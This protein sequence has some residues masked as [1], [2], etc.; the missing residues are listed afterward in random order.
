VDLLVTAVNRGTEE[1]RQALAGYPET[2]DR[3]LCFRD[4]DAICPNADLLLMSLDKLEG[5]IGQTL[6][7]YPGTA[8]QLVRYLEMIDSNVVRIKNNAVMMRQVIQGLA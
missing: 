3:L 1:I 2:A 7:G 4:I 5:V 8:R 6:A